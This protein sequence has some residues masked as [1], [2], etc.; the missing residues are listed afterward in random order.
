MTIIIEHP[1]PLDV[2]I[3]RV[4]LRPGIRALRAPL[5]PLFPLG[6]PGGYITI[7]YA[8]SH[9]L[10]RQRLNGGAEIVTSAWLGWI[11]HRAVKLVVERERPHERGRRRRFDSWP[12]G[13]TTGATALALTMA[14]VLYR[15]RVITKRQAI[16]IATGVPLV[17]GAYRIIADEHWTT[18]VMGGWAVGTAIAAMVA[19]PYMRA[20]GPRVRRVRR[21]SAA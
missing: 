9:Q 19:A 16:A 15:E 4:A 10:K 17:M 7:A 8:T 6:L 13:H 11:V 3:R 1:T 12:S 5:W 2:A 21:R 14:R 18:D 20:R